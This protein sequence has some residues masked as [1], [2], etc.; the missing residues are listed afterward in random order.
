MS[1]LMLFM[2]FVCLFAY[3]LHIVPVF[4]VFFCKKVLGLSYLS[5][6]DLDRCID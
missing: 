4:K 2:L 6:Y 1:E 5:L 3:Q